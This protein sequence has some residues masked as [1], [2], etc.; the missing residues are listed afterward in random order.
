MRRQLTHLR[1]FLASPS[2]LKDERIALESVI[3]ELNQMLSES[4]GAY[5]ELT[6]WET[7]AVVSLPQK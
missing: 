2:D 3:K 5:L 7:D 6:K 4:T 1:V